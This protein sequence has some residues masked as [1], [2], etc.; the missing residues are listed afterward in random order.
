MKPPPKTTRGFAVRLGGEEVGRVEDDVAITTPDQTR[1]HFLQRVRL[2][3]EKVREFGSEYAYRI[4]YYSLAARNPKWVFGYCSLLAD[5]Q[6]K[7]LL[8][9]ARLKGWPI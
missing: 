1:I 5:A 9:Q 8:A 2:D 3:P 6:L 7:D 4:C